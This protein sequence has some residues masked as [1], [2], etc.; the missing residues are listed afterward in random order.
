MC[1]FVDFKPGFPPVSLPI[2]GT[3]AGALS[4]PLSSVPLPPP[5]SRPSTAASGKICHA[6]GCKSGRIRKDCRRRMCK[7]HCREAGGC[8][9]P[10]HFVNRDAA[11]QD[12]IPRASLVSTAPPLASQ[13]SLSVPPNSA[14]SSFMPASFLPSQPAPSAS[15]P[16]QAIPSTPHRIYASHM[17]PIFTEQMI[18]E[19]KLQTQRRKSEATH[20]VNSRKA[21]HTVIVY[22]WTEASNHV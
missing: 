10:P 14:T 8:L 6:L 18:A 9:D 4:I 5:P 2:V 22:A 12:P 17:I 1:N 7:K 21:K 3:Q 16:S 13:P 19:Q 15:A 20:T 11:C